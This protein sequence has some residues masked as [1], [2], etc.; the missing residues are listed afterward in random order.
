MDSGIYVVPGNA[1]MIQYVDLHAHGGR[2]HY[3]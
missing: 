3:V 1:P 2:G